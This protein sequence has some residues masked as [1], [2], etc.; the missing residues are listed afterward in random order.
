MN[1]D[2]SVYLCLTHYLNNTLQH[3]TRNLQWLLRNTE[4]T[5]ELLCAAGWLTVLSSI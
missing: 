2:Y 4:R 5:I 1:T 3:T